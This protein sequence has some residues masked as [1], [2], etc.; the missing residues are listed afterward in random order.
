MLR[1]CN[2]FDVGC[3]VH[4]LAVIEAEERLAFECGN[5][6]AEAGMRSSGGARM[7]EIFSLS[8]GRGVIGGADGRCVFVR[9]CEECCG[10]ENNQ[11]EGSESAI[12]DPPMSLRDSCGFKKVWRTKMVSPAGD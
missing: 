4:E 10:E 3:R 1:G 2:D 11:C 5:A 12:Q 6:D 9:L 8:S 7:A